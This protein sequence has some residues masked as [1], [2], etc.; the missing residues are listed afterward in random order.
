MRKKKKSFFHGCL[1]IRRLRPRDGNTRVFRRPWPCCRSENSSSVEHDRMYAGNKLPCT[2]RLSCDIEYVGVTEGESSRMNCISIMAHAEISAECLGK[3][4]GD[5]IGICLP[6]R[7]ICSMSKFYIVSLLLRDDYAN[8]YTL[9][10]EETFCLILFDIC[11]VFLL[12]KLTIIRV[13][14]CDST[15]L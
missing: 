5:Y 12:R 8:Y 13:K 7:W 9:E 2:S 3:A 1:V 11:L 10:T 15:L 14:I 4:S 6:I